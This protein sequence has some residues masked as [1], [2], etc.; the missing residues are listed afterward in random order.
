MK[1]KTLLVMF[2]GVFA[3]PESGRDKHVNFYVIGNTYI[4]ENTVYW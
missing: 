3:I 1:M 2:I 4:T